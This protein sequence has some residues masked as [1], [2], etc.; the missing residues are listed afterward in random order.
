MASAETERCLAIEEAHTN[1]LPGPRLAARRGLA[2]VGQSSKDRP[3]T[4][5]KF[6]HPSL[7][8]RLSFCASAGAARSRRITRSNPLIGLTRGETAMA[9]RAAL[10]SVS[11]HPLYKPKELRRFGNFDKKGTS[12]AARL[13]QYLDPA[14]GVQDGDRSVEIV[15]S[16]LAKDD[17]E[18][19]VK[20]GQTGV[21]ADIFDSKR[22]K[23]LHQ[24]PE[25]SHEINSS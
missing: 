2:T 5:L 6:I 20:H 7:V 10:Y 18:P 8:A 4:D 15:S 21:A 11:V 24:N 22:K 1:L 3:G 14:F 12:L 19:V 17:L 13:D 9:H 16:N 25:D 23:R